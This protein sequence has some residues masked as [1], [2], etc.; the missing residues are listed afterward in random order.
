MLKEAHVAEEWPETEEVEAHVA[1]EWP[2]TEGVDYP[3]MFSWL[4]ASLAEATPLLD[5]DDMHLCLEEGKYTRFADS[6]WERFCNFVFWILM[7][8]LSRI[9]GNLDQHMKQPYAVRMGYLSFFSMLEI[10]VIHMQDGPCLQS[11]RVAY[12]R[13]AGQ[14]HYL[15]IP[16]ESISLSLLTF[17][18]LVGHHDLKHRPKSV[19]EALHHLIFAILMLGILRCSQPEDYDL[20]WVMFNI[21]IYRL[22]MH[23]SWLLFG[24]KFRKIMQSALGVISL[25]VGLHRNSRTFIHQYIPLKGLTEIWYCYALLPLLVPGNFLRDSATLNQSNFKMAKRTLMALIFAAS[26]T[27]HNLL[28]LQQQRE[29]TVGVSATMKMTQFVCFAAFGSILPGKPSVLSN[30]GDSALTVLVLHS[31]L[32]FTLNGVFDPLVDA[33]SPLGTGLM[34]LMVYLIAFGIQIVTSFEFR[35]NRVPFCPA[36]VRLPVI[37]PPSWA[38]FIGAWCGLAVLYC[39]REL[40]NP[41]A[42]LLPP[43]LSSL[44]PRQYALN[45]ATIPVGLT[46]C[47]KT[48]MPVNSALCQRSMDFTVRLDPDLHSCRRL[49]DFGYTPQSLLQCAVLV[50]SRPEC[51]QNFMFGVAGCMCCKPGTALGRRP[52]QIWSHPSWVVW[53]ASLLPFGRLD[54]SSSTSIAQLMGIDTRKAYAPNQCTDP[55]NGQEESLNHTKWRNVR[56]QL[57]CSLLVFANPRCSGMFLWSSSRQSCCCCGSGTAFERASKAHD[58]PENEDTHLQHSPG[59]AL[60]GT[61]SHQFGLARHQPSSSFPMSVSASLGL[62]DIEAAWAWE[63]AKDA[64]DLVPETYKQTAFLRIIAAPRVKMRTELET[65]RAI[66]AHLHHEGYDYSHGKWYAELA[67]RRLVQAGSALKEAGKTYDYFKEL[68]RSERAEEF[69]NFVAWEETHDQQNEHAALVYRRVKLAGGSEILARRVFSHLMECPNQSKLFRKCTGNT[70]AGANAFEH[71]RSA[72]LTSAQAKGVHK[73]ISSA[74]E[75]RRDIEYTRAFVHL[76]AFLLHSERYNASP[77]TSE[78]WGQK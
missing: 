64:A 22:L 67:Y 74:P 34:K 66:A 60:P 50:V 2:E 51:D 42:V 18:F 33:I 32:T 10:I 58:L 71:L 43:E 39:R 47:S 41:P 56:S 3:N 1:E 28:L 8:S 70:L 57:Q 19:L 69:R 52:T 36:W 6:T 20:T 29:P 49:V 27:I 17:V 38:L 16:T 77:P 13:L 54:N 25:T 9:F 63:M 53:K 65:I 21:I 7:D 62:T 72:G 48:T 23:T 75:F 45:S 31:H 61:S 40:V 46:P 4:R 35:F 15:I 11:I 59:Y 14:E 78:V 37:R 76:S 30:I 5:R 55:L 73:R 68:P 26:F 24:G 12:P 44:L